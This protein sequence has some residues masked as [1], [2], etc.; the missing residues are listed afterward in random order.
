MQKYSTMPNVKLSIVIL[1]HN[2][3][4]NVT[5]CLRSIQAANLPEAYE[6]LVLDN[7]GKNAN[8]Q[9]EP[10]AY[11]QLPISFESI[12]NDGFPAGQN[13]GASKT[14]GEYIAVINPDIVLEPQCLELLL[15][16]MDTNT[17][18]GLSTAQLY[19]PN[20]TDQDNTRKFPS[21]LG[22]ITRKLFGTVERA[23]P[24]QDGKNY[25]AID[26]C[27]GALW[28]LRRSN[29]E[30]IGGHDERYF[31]FMSDIGLG[32]EM[33]A[34]NFAVHQVRGARAQHG[35]ERLSGGNVL[36]ML[37]KKTG[38]IHIKDACIYFWHYFGKSA[39]SGSPSSQ[40]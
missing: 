15:Q 21:I 2:T 26:W 36:S 16:H 1:H 18:V 10:A 38:R 22:I 17:N 28:L 29:L 6:V 14:S 24:L 27:T 40:R 23:E 34:H 31:L 12:A 20:G 11:N 33:W 5:E 13:Y 25:R 30:A 9:I 7:G 37:R 32:R 8:D 4:Q 19:Y 3:P 39:P 35:A